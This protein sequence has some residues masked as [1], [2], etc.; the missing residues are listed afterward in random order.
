VEGRVDLPL[1]Y[2][3]ALMNSLRE[4][5]RKRLIRLIDQI[6]VDENPEGW[7][8]IA[9]IAVGGLLSVGFSQ[10]GPYLLVVSSSGRSVVRCDTGEKIER[11]YEEYAGLS[12]LGLHCQGIGV[13]ADEVIPLC[14]IQG[15]G[16][17]T[18][19]I[20]GEGL[21]LVS[22]DWPENSLILSKP[23][24]NALIEGHQAD[25]TVIYRD[26]VRAFGFSWCGNYI[27]AACSS[28][29]DLWSRKSKL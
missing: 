24:K 22:P 27:V 26:H 25:C 12:E 1:F 18:G 10:K 17:P 5:N 13:I 6:P 3:N 19:N 11:D 23:F 4:D 9:S 15:G 14:G 20:A 2:P 21:A 29:L 8:H 28:D 7:T 16:L